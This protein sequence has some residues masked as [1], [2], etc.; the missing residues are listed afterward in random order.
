MKRTLF[1][2]HALCLSCMTPALPQD[3]QGYSFMH[4]NSETGLSQSNVKAIIQDSYGFMWFGTKNGLNRY[5]GQ[6]V[7][8]FDCYDHARRRGNQN[9]S[10]L[11][12]DDRRILW[13]GTDEGV[14]RYDPAADVFTFLDARTDKGETIT[15]WI[16]TI[17]EDAKGDIWICA[18]SQGIFRYDEKRLHRYSDFPDGSYPHN[19]C[20]CDNG[21]IYAVSWYTGLLKYD[22]RGRR[23][24]QIKED[25]GGRPLL[26]LEINTLSQQG[27]RLVMS[28]Q[29]GDLKKYDFRRNKLEDV[30]L[31]SLR[32]TFTRFATVYGDEIYAGTYDGL[33]VINEKARSVR[34]F[35]Q[36]L[37]NPSGLADNIVYSAYRDREGGLWV[38]TM[39][40]GVNYLLN[41][42]FA[43]RKYLPGY[44]ENSLSSKRIRELAEDGRG[45][46]WI[47]TEDAGINVMS[48]ASHEVR[49]YPL[50]QAN[51]NTHVT[52]VVGAYGDNVY[53]SLYKDGL[54]VVDGQGKST[55]YNYN[56]L[57]VG[58]GGCSI[59]ALYMDREGTLWAGSDFGVFYAPKGTFRFTALPELKGQWVFDILQEKNGTFW[60]ATMGEGVWKYDPRNNAFKHY[61]N[62]DGASGR[63]GSNP[64]SSNSVSSLMQDSKG[65]VWLSTDRGG[66]CRYNPKGDDF[67]R[68]SVEEGMP[69][70]VAYKVLEDDYGYLWFGT[71]RGLVR[72]KPETKEIRVFT[73][74]DGLCG[75]QFNYKSA[76]KGSDGNFYFGSIEGLV[77]FNPN[78]RE[79]TAPVPPIY[80]TRFS[81]FNEEVTVH[82]PGSLLKQSIIGTDKIVLPYNQANISFDIALLSYSTSQTNEY[83]YRLEPVDKQ[84]IR[85]EAGNSI[86]YANL[87]PGKYALHLRAT[88]NE[89]APGNARYA[90]R[91]LSI[92]IL[93]PWYASTWAYI[94]YAILGSC[95][96][97]GG[98]YWY[99]RHKNK[100]ISEQQKLFEMEKEKELNQ[101]K[102]EFFTKIA[103][104]IRT[105]LTLINGPLEIIQE[106][107][108]QD[109]KLN[110]N[111][112]VM[113]TNT[114]RLLDLASQLLDFQKMGSNKLTLNYEVVN[115][116]EL[117]QETV[118]RF[119][120][121][122]THLHKELK[123]E[124]PGNDIIA[125]V[126]KEGITKILSN[127]LNNA[128]KYGDRHVSVKLGDRDG[129]F[130]VSVCSDGAR[131]PEEKAE[132]IFEPF[133]QEAGKKEERQGV[134][135]GLA[136]A[137]SLALL[138]KGT[139]M[140]DTSQPGNTF[141]L[142]VPLNTEDMT[143]DGDKSFGKDDFPLAETTSAEECAEGNVILIVEDEESIRDF[144]KE[145]L[146][147][148]FIVETASSG[149]EALDILR[150]EHIDL[151]ISDVMM[152][153]MNGY[154]LCAAI[155]SDISLCHVPVMFLT[156][157]NDMDSKIKGLKAGA[158]AY[159]EKPFSYDYLKA[160]L[161]SLLDNRQKE[162]EAFSKRPFFPMRN[163][164][165]SREDEE[166]MGKVIEVINA[167]LEDETFNVERM[168]EDLCLSRSSLLR[169][170]K[171]LFN[172]SPIDFIRLIRLKKAA[173]LIQEGKYRVGEICYMVGFS[174]HSYFSK[175]FSKQFGM[176]P[177]DFEKQISNTRSKVRNSQ[178]INIED[179]IQGNKTD[180]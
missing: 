171:T 23:F 94:I 32:H 138:H 85:K 39:Y 50:P 109:E 148:L 30:T 10:A 110:K 4:I 40:S 126:D 52:I 128:L 12:E 176:T 17:L 42:T 53:C 9:I 134:G 61:T 136:L 115:I 33:Y 172:L 152:P 79:R 96:F 47:G 14:F 7:V 88:T 177:K 153:G 95:A 114:K 76:V 25:A 158:E 180:P 59:Y 68:F 143:E 156:A 104:E 168:A 62:K 3:S 132:Q 147:P 65:N 60:F 179:L 146:S 103:H 117:L 5:D 105:P 58:S 111:L 67:T 173:E 22:A 66:L 28:I 43:F 57:H 11:F 1:L 71:N 6:R 92:V 51:F 41:N 69:D 102:V 118:N 139:L 16:S 70:D 82:T 55:F 38:G 137:R 116:S 72:F 29:N 93:P 159:I 124:K 48:L 144:M 127:L 141:V 149:R 34:H 56:E 27:D 154:E 129:S 167:N 100:Q 26:D 80:V 49:R 36:D 90:T 89:G 107:H 74:H 170:I 77:S 24:V 112:N 142:T 150:K 101:N 119:E 133:F 97:C 145:R 86:S 113:A 108:I 21:D 140:L 75:N 123:V 160:Q 13:I 44:R 131:I 84:W 46:L 151:V 98:F 169:K 45:N 91:S 64:V 78:V 31:Q 155:K 54:V 8:R 163:M 162:R 81:I 18:P 106:M 161:L 99:W 121:T 122:F 166:F 83:F 130:S 175:L 135:I 125:R 164:Q 73:V 15:S 2:L 19:I 174:S 157:K 120:P 178:E 35:G 37:L 63:A 87:A 20:I 165:M